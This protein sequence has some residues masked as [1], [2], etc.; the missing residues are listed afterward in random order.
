[1][2]A[3]L[4]KLVEQALWTLPIDFPE[5]GPSTGGLLEL[6]AKEPPP[7]A[8][9]AFEP[10]MA[11]DNDAKVADAK[12]K[13]SAKAKKRKPKTPNKVDQKSSTIKDEDFLQEV[14]L[15]SAEDA[16]KEDD[17]VEQ[18]ADEDVNVWEMMKDSVKEDA[19]TGQDDQPG[20]PDIQDDHSCAASGNDE[21]PEDHQ[22]EPQLNDTAIQFDLMQ[23]SG[24]AQDATV[25]CEE[26]I[27]EGSS[28]VQGERFILPPRTP[29][30][31]PVAGYHNWHPNQLVCYIWNQ[32]SRLVAPDDPEDSPLHRSPH[33]ICSAQPLTPASRPLENR[34]GWCRPGRSHLSSSTTPRISEKG[35]TPRVVTAVVKNT[36]IDIEDDATDCPTSITR[37]TKSLS[38][39]HSH[40]TPS[41]TRGSWTPSLLAAD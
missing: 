11:Q 25:V 9:V 38:P 23:S 27:K 7:E 33:Q 8:E 4:A 14:E 17:E 40:R 24:V 10:W 3:Q 28:R 15:E 2:K 16:I 32:T 34:L 18:P 37:S 29:P 39:S 1:M 21:T 30:P 19:V 31:S 12:N 35:P 26:S 5:P 22:C 41:W 36:F 6:G 20:P 13:K